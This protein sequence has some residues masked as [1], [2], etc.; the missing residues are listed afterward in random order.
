MMQRKEKVRGDIWNP[1]HHNLSI[2]Q[3]THDFH[4]NKDLVFLNLII[5]LILLPLKNGSQV[6]V[7]FL[8]YCI[9]FRYKSI[10]Q[11]VMN[12]GTALK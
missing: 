12:V 10:L 9:T 7:V 2:P 11:G 8:C 3:K 6:L 4:L 5:F 1:Y